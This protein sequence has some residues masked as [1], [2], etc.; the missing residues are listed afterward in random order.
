[1]PPRLTALILS[2]R[3]KYIFG[4]IQFRGFSDRTD[5]TLIPTINPDGFDRAT[6]GR[7]VGKS[8]FFVRNITEMDDSELR[9]YHTL[10]S[11]LGTFDAFNGNYD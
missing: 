10:F 7:C 11:L 9:N 4:R 6:E 3:Q 8:T 2:K 1:M 5:I